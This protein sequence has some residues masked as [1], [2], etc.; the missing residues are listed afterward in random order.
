MVRKRKAYPKEYKQ[1]VL[2]LLMEGT[3][4]SK[5]VAHRLGMP[6]RTVQSWAQTAGISG[7]LAAGAPSERDQVVEMMELREK[8]RQRKNSRRAQLRGAL[9]QRSG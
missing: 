2:A 9:R 3:R 6:L 7:R 1:S 4:T 5:E 8:L